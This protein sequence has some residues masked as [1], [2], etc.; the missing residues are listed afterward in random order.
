MKLYAPIIAATLLLAIPSCRFIHISDNLKQQL[1]EAGSD[2]HASEDGKTIT[3]SDVIAERDE[4]PGD[5]KA[6]ESK[7]ACDITYVSGDCNISFSGPDNILEHITV[8]NEAGR[9]SVGSDGTNFRKLKNL[10]IVLTAPSLEEL[11]FKGAVDFSAPQGICCPGSFK[12]EIDGA[13]DIDIQGLKAGRAAI[14]VNGA[15]D[16]NVDAIDSD[17][18]SIEINGA[19][20]A[21]VSGKTGKATMSISGAGDIDARNLQ[22]EQFDS[23]VRGAGSIKRPRN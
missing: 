20:D 10:K 23:K 12:I 8:V 3:A 13:G 16:I 4:Q 21:V 17:E 19:G 11:H 5:F 2:F 1:K 14:T 18:L 7:L 15:G 22:A 9:L 6:F